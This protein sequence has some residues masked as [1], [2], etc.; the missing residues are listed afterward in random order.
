MWLN[1]DREHRERKW[2]LGEVEQCR[3]G[4]HGFY[5]LLL[6]AWPGVGEQWG[7]RKRFC[8]AAVSALEGSS[9]AAT[10]SQRGVFSVAA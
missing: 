3:D 1:K 5:V 7:I 9:K 6:L 2:A 8:G 10:S 4:G